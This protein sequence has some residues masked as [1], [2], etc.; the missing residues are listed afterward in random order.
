MRALALALL[1]ILALG[2]PAAL[3]HA[4]L[5]HAKP[6]VGSVLERAPTAISLWFTQE[7]EPAFSTAEVVD[8][9][10]NRVDSG[11]AQVDR[12]DPT[13]L[14]VPLKPLSAGRYKVNWRVVSVDSHTTEGS[15]TFRVGGE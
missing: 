10:G 13:L 2:A 5:D 8:P 9:S 3:A 11:N 15:F 7:L 4:F 6:S 1:P 12:K 14:R